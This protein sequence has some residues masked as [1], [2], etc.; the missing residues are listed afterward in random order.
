[1]EL[2]TIE[3]MHA[4]LKQ[5]YKPDR[6]EGRNNSTCGENYSWVC[7]Q[8]ALDHVAQLG[9]SCVS[10][11]ESKTGDAVWFGPDLNVITD[12]D[13]FRTRLRESAPSGKP[14]K[15]RQ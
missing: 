4:F 15:G 14:N 9:M 10:Q 11:Y 12:L 6:F 2:P 1:M 8:S 13:E 5:L 3:A 7:A